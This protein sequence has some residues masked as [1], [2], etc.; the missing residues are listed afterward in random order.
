MKILINC[1]IKRNQYGD[2]QAAQVFFQ[3]LVSNH[4]HDK[5]PKSL[6]VNLSKSGNPE[7]D[8]PITFLQKHNAHAGTF[9]NHETMRRYI[10]RVREDIVRV[11]TEYNME[12]E[13]TNAS[14]EKLDYAVIEENEDLH[15]PPAPALILPEGVLLIDMGNVPELT[16]DMLIELFDEDED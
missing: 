10:D 2:F 9:S 5:I 15:P 12:Q 8:T 7:C 6:K 14:P 4:E 16:D 1:Y 13:E 11:A 3:S